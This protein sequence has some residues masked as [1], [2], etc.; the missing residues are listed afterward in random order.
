[1]SA[2][3]QFALALATL[4]LATLIGCSK[5]KPE[6]TPVI[7]EKTPGTFN[8]HWDIGEQENC[9]KQSDAVM[10]SAPVL[11]C[12][13][14]WTSWWLACSQGITH[15]APFGKNIEDAKREMLANIRVFPV[16]FAGAGM[17]VRASKNR[18]PATLW[19]CIKQEDGSIYCR[20]STKK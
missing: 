3:H 7:L 20:S 17:A 19:F 2:T 11:L 4:A 9:F 5:T 13:E 12:G 18:L 10:D 15:T 14:A 6:P 1:M 8:A 16:Y